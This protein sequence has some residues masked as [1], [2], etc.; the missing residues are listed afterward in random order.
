ME[1]IPGAIAGLKLLSDTGFRL[2]VITNQSGVARGYFPEQSVID[3]HQE[4]SR[5]LACYRVN[6]DAFRFCPHHPKGLVAKYR[7]ICECR[8]PAPMLFSTIASEYDVDIGQSFAIGD[9]IRDVTPLMDLGGTGIVL[10]H[11]DDAGL[12]YEGYRASGLHEAAE[13]VVRLVGSA[14]VEP[15]SE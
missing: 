1:F 6:I 5:R 2:F 14:A 7:L 10:G 13:L 9:R 12:K 3:F 8:K 15:V 4:M 11:P